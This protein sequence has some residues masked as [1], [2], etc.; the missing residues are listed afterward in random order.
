[1]KPSIFSLEVGKSFLVILFMFY[2]TQHVLHVFNYTYFMNEYRAVASLSLAPFL[3]SV[4]LIF[5]MACFDKIIPAIRLK[6]VAITRRL[7]WLVVLLV[8]IIPLTYVGYWF[9]QNASIAFRYEARL[10]DFGAV[11]YVMAA[12][13]FIF[14]F[15]IFLTVI[16]IIN[17]KVLSA[18]NRLLLIYCSF[19][20]GLT[21][22]GTLDLM[23]LILAVFLGV[24]PKFFRNV[25]FRGKELTFFRG[26]LG[27]FICVAVIAGMV[28]FGFANK[29]GYASA[30]VRIIGSYQDIL[31]IVFA[32]VSSSYATVVSLNA[33][34]DF[35][36]I[37]AA[38]ITGS[39]ETLVYR[40]NLLFGV[41]QV[42]RDVTGS[43]GRQ[44]YIAVFNDYLPRA[45]ASPGP[46]GSLFYFP[47]MPL[48]LMV[49]ALFYISI[50]RL[51]QSFIKSDAG[52]LSFI[53]I[54]ILCITLLP[55]LENP[56]EYAEL[57][58]APIVYLTCF[59]LGLFVKVKHQQLDI[60]STDLK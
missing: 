10:S 27:L 52:E 16:S 18:P 33:Q 56:Y 15:H 39:W 5:L 51:V 50:L 6:K 17:N 48:S 40:F 54:F 47:F 30:Y 58:G 42:A 26:I 49:H 8:Y 19:F 23:I 38:G 14:R 12:Q 20:F 45:G 11:T 44:N 41:D 34:L 7:F 55:F 37:D 36:N 3:M 31:G 59:L 29:E 32:R 46:L 13:Q 4:A 43:V 53:T 28:F 22:T 24:F 60:K 9:Y 1:M 57:I 35:W 2:G 25:F 21:I